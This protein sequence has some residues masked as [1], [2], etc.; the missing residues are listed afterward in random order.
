MAR[1]L[2][3][4]PRRQRSVAVTLAALERTPAASTATALNVQ[5]PAASLGSASDHAPRFS[6]ARAARF[7][8]TT[9]LPTVPA[10]VTST[11]A[12]PRAVPRSRR[13]AVLEARSLAHA[14]RLASFGQAG[15]AI[16]TI[17]FGFGVATGGG[18]VLGG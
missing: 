10:T 9:R 6:L 7:T 16:F 4:V 15:R 1:T 18:A 5:R 17:G 13:H 8:V 12:A 3:P 14:F 11:R 2:S